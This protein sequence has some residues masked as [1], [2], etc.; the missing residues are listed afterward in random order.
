MGVDKSHKSVVEG[1]WEEDQDLA[2][3]TSAPIAV[4]AIKSFEGNKDETLPGYAPR[5]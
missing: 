3:A 4:L 5:T 2:N 1:R